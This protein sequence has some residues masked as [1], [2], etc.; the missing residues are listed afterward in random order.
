MYLGEYY[1]RKV[2]F[3]GGIENG[4]SKYKDRGDFISDFLL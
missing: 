4:V 1:G 2:F 3:L